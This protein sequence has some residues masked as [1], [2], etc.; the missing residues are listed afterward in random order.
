MDVPIRCPGCGFGL[1]VPQDTIGR[2]IRCRKCGEIFL[3]DPPEDWD[4]TV[5]SQSRTEGSRPARRDHDEFSVVESP[6]R[7][8]NSS[9]LWIAGI[10]LAGVL[11]L[12]GGVAAVLGFVL[13]RKPAPA[14]AVAQANAADGTVPGET[15]Q[16]T[17][18]ARPFKPNAPS[19]DGQL[20]K[21]MLDYL[22][23]LTVFIKLNAGQAEGSAS[24]FLIKV[25]GD[26]GYIV[27]NEHVVNMEMPEPE[28]RPSPIGPRLGPRNMPQPG[29]PRMPNLPGMPN[30]PDFPN[31][32][33]P[34]IFEE[35]QSARKVHPKLTVVFGSGTANERSM[36]G[37]VLDANSL[38]D[39]A[40]VRV[41]GPNLPKPIDLSD[42]AELTETM[43]AYVLGFPLGAALSVEGNPAITVNKT[44]VG[45]IRKGK[46]GMPVFVQLQ[47]GRNPG[48]SGG[49]VVDAD[50]RLVGI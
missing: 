12:G 17:Q 30:F 46:N 28:R 47:A 21:E 49:P 45:S 20:A 48:N 26:T 35:P 15:A 39:L 40:L 16:P 18:P 31:M 4:E 9:A 29:G 50:G 1:N 13:L 2:K 44:T 8:R 22:K 38:L 5:G 24:G 33:L 11:L 32:P 27:T 3:V 37:E 7:F 42:R 34:P 14:P 6:E 36:P 25:D 23:D 10:V 19:K 41:K 43:T